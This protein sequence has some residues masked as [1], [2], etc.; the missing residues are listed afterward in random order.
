MRNANELQLQ[1]F[2]DAREVQA[3]NIYNE[4][5]LELL[6]GAQKLA[7]LSFD[8]V[9]EHGLSHCL[10]YGIIKNEQ[11]FYIKLIQK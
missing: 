6:K 9:C 3:N 1:S 5:Q 7:K 2:Y 10:K 11:N 4:M 8:I